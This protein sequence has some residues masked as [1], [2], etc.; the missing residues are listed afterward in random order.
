MSN[1]FL[2]KKLNQG[3]CKSSELTQIIVEKCN[4]SKA[5]ARKRLTRLPSPIS[6]LNNITLPNNESVFLLEEHRDSA[7]F[8]Y[9][10][11]KILED[12]NT[13]EGR[14]LRAIGLAGQTIPFAYLAKASGTLF[15][16]P[17]KGKHSY[18][19]KI[20][21]HLLENGLVEFFQDAR[22]G[23]IV[24][25]PGWQA[26]SPSTRAILDVE[27][28]FLSMIQKWLI[29]LGFS[30]MKAMQ[31][32]QETKC[33]LHGV[34]EWDLMGPCYLNGLLFK[35]AKT[36][37]NGFIVGD[38]VLGKK[39][40]KED[41]KPFFYK[42][43]SLNNQP[44]TLPFQSLYIADSFEPNALNMLRNKGIMIA[45]PYN[46]YGGEVA[47]LLASLKDVLSKAYESLKNTPED[48]FKIIEKIIKIEGA[49]LNLRGIFLDLLVARLYSRHGYTCRIR[50][51]YKLNNGDGFEF[52]VVAE[53]ADE[54]IFVEGKALASGNA[55]NLKEVEKWATTTLPRFMRWLKEE[56]NNHSVTNSI[57]F[58]VSTE[59][60]PDCGDY[61]SS[62]TTRNK[63]VRIKFYDSGYITQQLTKFHDNTILYS[64]KEQFLNKKIEL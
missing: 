12:N 26:M 8:K 25:A 1:E 27:S 44:K 23:K 42:L 34:F 49:A 21:D 59:F 38:I 50:E 2:L 57:V 19:R 30:S 14:V 48:A 41:L 22:Y 52:D 5:A 16:L 4:L 18:L 43:D 62:L 51:K 56:G 39:I 3:P 31:V 55:L 37:K 28:I 15:R 46:I 36:T 11:Q 47:E 63:K 29:N 58:V 45:S 10:I 60:H 6:R 35:R 24:A 53:R 20:L 64:F 13:A 61:I 9:L 7:D 54:R 33:C 40:T 17:S 32:R